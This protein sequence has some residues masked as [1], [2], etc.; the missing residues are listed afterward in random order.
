MTPNREEKLVIDN[1]SHQ[2]YEN[3]LF[4]PDGNLPPDIL[5]DNKIAIEVRRLNQ[6]QKTALKDSNKMNFQFTEF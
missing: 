5:V 6:N 1:L 4:E 2:G 3:I